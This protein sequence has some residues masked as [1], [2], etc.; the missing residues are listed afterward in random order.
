MQCIKYILAMLPFAAAAQFDTV[1]IEAYVYTDSALA[2][3]ARDTCDQAYNIPSGVYY[4]TRH[5]V[6]A[7]KH[8]DGFWFIRPSEYTIPLSTEP[9]TIT[10][11]SQ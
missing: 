4:V 1:Q 10:I 9:Q 2:M 5:A 11:I 3:L 8:R 6:A 7:E